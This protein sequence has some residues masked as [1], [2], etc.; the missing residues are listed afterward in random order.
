MHLYA[1]EYF[2]GSQRTPNRAL[3]PI[4]RADNGSLFPDNCPHGCCSI[5][6]LTVAVFPLDASPS[7]FV[8]TPGS[9]TGVKVIVPSSAEVAIAVCVTNCAPCVQTV[10]GAQGGVHA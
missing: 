6:T 1:Q 10:C 3:R 4:L 5:A 7:R 9:V 2:I 8:A